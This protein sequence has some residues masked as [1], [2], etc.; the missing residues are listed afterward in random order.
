MKKK[1]VF[2]SL[3]LLIVVGG[4]VVVARMD[5]NKQTPLERH[6]EQINQ[7][8]NSENNTLSTSPSGE[9]EQVP[10]SG[11]IS[12]SNVMYNNRHTL[13][14]QII[15]YEVYDDSNILNQVQF[16]IEYYLEDRYPNPNYIYNG[17]AWHNL[18]EDYPEV[19]E[20]LDLDYEDYI[21]SS[22]DFEGFMTE[23]SDEYTISE[24]P[25]TRYVFVTIEVTNISDNEI[26]ESVPQLLCI[27][28]DVQAYDY[29]IHW[30]GASMV[31]YFDY[32]PDLSGD[33]L[34]H[35][36]TWYNFAP[37]ETHRFT[38]GYTLRAYPFDDSPLLFSDN[39]TYYY[40]IPFPDEQVTSPIYFMNSVCLNEL[41]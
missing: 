40:C 1:I 19:A 22:F 9:V 6:I 27:E 32:I 36:R 35:K 14:Y 4:T 16:P 39:D 30:Y 26:Y 33:E 17:I 31:T 13:E 3:A 10:D 28:N 41:R 18:R 8:Q 7:E 29:D 23:H 25:E 5:N 11:E 21:N 20:Y 15:T 37:G 34:L 2:V 24:H 12:D 38:I